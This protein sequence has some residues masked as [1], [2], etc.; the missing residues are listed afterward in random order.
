M[1]TTLTTKLKIDSWDEAPTQEFDDGTKLT[2]AEVALVG[3]ED[4]LASGSFNAV[5]YYRPDGT[6]SYATVMRLSGTLDGGT[7]DFALVGEGT[8][9]GTTASSRSRIV[10]GS[11][12]G[13]LVGI[14]GTCQSDSTQA[15]Y[16]FMPL[17][18]T[19]ELG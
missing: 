16:P 15:D 13:D 12:T 8:Y 9:D 3:N 1:S 4:G 2:R 6:S 11:G 19:Y 18:L 7:G 17:S 5:M 10:D 14:T